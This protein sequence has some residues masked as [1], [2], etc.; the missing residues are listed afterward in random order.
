MSRF[1]LLAVLAVTMLAPLAAGCSADTAG[2]DV[3]APSGDV[4]GA[5]GEGE[6]EIRRGGLLGQLGAVK[7]NGG[8]IVAAPSKIKRILENIGLQ[9]GAA[10]P[11]EGGFRCMPSYRLEF[12]KPSGE[13]AGTAGFMCGGPGSADRKDAKG[14]VQVG[15]K[16]YL[17]TA[18]DIDAIDAIAKEPA[19]VADLVYGADKVVFSK[20][21]SQAAKVETNN[22]EQVA[23]VLSG[24]KADQVPDRNASFPRCLPSKVVTIQKG[25][26]ELA[27]IGLNCGDDATGIVR[28]RLTAGETMGAVD[29]DAGIV[30]GVEKTL[31]PSQN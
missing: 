17:I 23:K 2:D 18:K 20:P 1:R 4:Q 22:G 14:S 6:D 29:V 15:G 27:S 9:P 31:S 10:K 30:L 12:F 8:A 21:T 19:A 16:S 7:V 26:K 28:G 13:V 24:L 11:A 3:N 25:T 5:G